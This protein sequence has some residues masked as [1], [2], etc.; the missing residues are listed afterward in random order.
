MSQITIEAAAERLAELVSDI[1]F[2]EEIILLQ[3]DKPVAKIVPLGTTPKLP[4]KR[5]YA[6][7]HVLYMAPEFDDTPEGFEDYLT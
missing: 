4:V 5:G 2:G 1:P 3:N 7:G 6:K